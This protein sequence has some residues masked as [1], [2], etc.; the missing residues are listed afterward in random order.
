[1]AIDI[2]TAKGQEICYELIK[3]AD[4]VVENFAS[5]AQKGSE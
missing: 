1:M 4:V 5:G 3:E 2:T